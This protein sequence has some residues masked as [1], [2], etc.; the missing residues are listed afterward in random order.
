MKNY[1]K[2]VLENGLRVILVEKPGSLAST[3]LVLVEAG[4]EYET[5]E[6]NGLSHFLEHMCFKGTAKR[7]KSI[8]ISGTLD[9]IGAEYNAFTSQEW[10]GYYAKAETKHLD[11][12]LDVVSDIYLNPK[13]DLKE[14]DKERGVIIEEIN[15]YEDNPPRR[16]QELFNQLLYGDQPA[17]W[18][19]GGRKEVIHKL[20]RED[21]I[22]YRSKNYLAQATTVVV[23]GSFKEAELLKKIRNHFAEMGTT[24][25]AVKAKTKEKQTKPEVLV[26]HKKSD[27]THIV[28]GVR[29]F[30]TFDE[31]RYALSVL[32]N[33]LGGGMS[34]RL[35]QKIREELG[36]AY[37]VR[38]SVDLALDHGFLE[39]SAGVHHE[40]T[41]EVIAAI[42]GELKRLAKEPVNSKELTRA[43][44]HLVGGLVLGLETSDA[45]AMYY[46]EQEVMKKTLLTPEEIMSKIQAVTATQIQGVAKDIMKNKNLN[47][48][49]IGPFERADEFKKILK[50]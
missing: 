41:K 6:I 31:R 8:D 5:K 29:A 25:K 22:T 27:Q 9:G 1:K 10:T 21:F 48:A 43:K 26:K 19:V 36:A 39:T 34:S 44:D 16:V 42:L 7:P 17:G 20:T 18:D 24:K 35:F 37:Y 38:A 40:K 12:I 47:L 15:M 30:D 49:M 4:S 11:L 23:V 3:V 33:I 14:I 50:F 13:F 28:L 32:S 2:T 46:G 45:V